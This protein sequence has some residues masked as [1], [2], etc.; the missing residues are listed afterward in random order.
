MNRKIICPACGS[1]AK[2]EARTYGLRASCCGL[3]S[4]G[5]KPLVD[6]ETHRAR[7]EA[8][9]AFD[10]LWRHGHWSRGRA[11]QELAARLGVPEPQAHMA[12]MDAATARRVPAIVAQIW[13][14][15]RCRRIERR[16]Y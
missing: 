7:Q 2:I 14:E 9:R 13:D 5:G 4:W 10:T 15:Q 8:H 16:A 1:D 6:A 11:Y 12:G 3:W